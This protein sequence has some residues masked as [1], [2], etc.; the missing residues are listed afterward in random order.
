[1]YTSQHVNNGTTLKACKYTA[2]VYK[3]CTN[4]DVQCRWE[5]LPNMHTR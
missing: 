3:L 4:L 2:G 5:Y 1:L